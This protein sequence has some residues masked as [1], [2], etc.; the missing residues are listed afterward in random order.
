MSELKAICAFDAY[1]EYLH[2]VD[3]DST[4]VYRKSEADRYIAC[5]KYKRCLAMA[6]WCDEAYHRECGLNPEEMRIKNF[7]NNKSNFGLDGI[8]SGS[9]LPRNSN[10]TQPPSRVKDNK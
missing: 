4:Q 7:I 2:T 5:L 10:Q 6:R 3:D 9:P 8:L 1:E